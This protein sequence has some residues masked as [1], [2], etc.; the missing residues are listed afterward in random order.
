MYL[1]NV[2][3]REPRL[4]YESTNVMMSERGQPMYLYN[5]MIRE[6]RFIY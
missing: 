2:M 4:S 6:P 5:V 1:Y 3:I